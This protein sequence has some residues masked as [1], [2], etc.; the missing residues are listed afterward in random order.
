MEPPLPRVLPVFPLTGVLLLP[1]GQLPLH[2]FE[3]RYRNMVADALQAGG[4]I[5]IIQPLTPRQDNRPP[6]GAE[7]ET[8]PL[9]EV[10]CAARLEGHEQA[11]DG[12]YLI[13]LR[14]LQ[15]FRIARELPQHGGYR[16]VE[17]EYG[18]FAGDSAEVVAELDNAP[19]LAA[20]AVYSAEKGIAVDWEQL[21]PLAGAV[22][23][24]TLAMAMPYAPP[25]K[26]ALLEAPTLAERERTLISLLKIGT[27]V[28]PEASHLTPGAN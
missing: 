26:Q 28:D 18:E 15:R 21:R 1:G 6:P 9:Y 24:T 19:L 11:P 3:P 16:R 25:E 14:G 20:L 10:G 27:T 12:R 5:G 8:P 2:I 7:G 4:H 23:L 13:R 22:L 17:A